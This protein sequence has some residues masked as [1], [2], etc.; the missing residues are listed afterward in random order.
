MATVQAR[1]ET[2]PLNVSYSEREIMLRLMTP[3]DRAK[4]IAFTSTLD[5]D[6]VMYLRLDIRQPEVVD[7]WVENLN[8]GLTTSV[9][10]FHADK[11]IGYASLH[12][13]GQHWTRHMAEMRLFVRRDFRGCG[14]GERL[15][16]EVFYNARD[17]GLDR[18]YVQIP[19]TQPRVRQMLTGQGFHPDALLPDWVMCGDGHTHDMVVMS[20]YIKEFA[21]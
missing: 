4:I 21:G 18:I 12:R 20:L 9:L 15:S 11:V 14:L 7:K 10:A 16:R 5:A 13:T 19:A 17:L 2:Y 8:A 3:D 1:K 6:D